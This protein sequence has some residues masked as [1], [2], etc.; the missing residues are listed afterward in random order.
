MSVV[1]PGELRVVVGWQNAH[2]VCGLLHLIYQMDG[3]QQIAY[4]S[5]DFAFKV[6]AVNLA[7]HEV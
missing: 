3:T 6:E 5:A 4:C 7:S 2:D 1:A